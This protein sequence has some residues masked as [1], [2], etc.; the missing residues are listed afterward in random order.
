MAKGSWPLQRCNMTYR[1]LGRECCYLTSVEALWADVFQ[2]LRGEEK[3]SITKG[4]F[5]G[6][7]SPICSRIRTRK[8][9]YHT[10]HTNIFEVARAY[11]LLSG[12]KYAGATRRLPKLRDQSHGSIQRPY[13]PFACVKEHGSC[14]LSSSSKVSMKGSSSPNYSPICGRVPLMGKC[15]LTQPKWSMK[16]WVPFNTGVSRPLRQ[17]KMIQGWPWSNLSHS[18]YSRHGSCTYNRS[19]VCLRH[20]F[21]HVDRYQSIF[22]C[23]KLVNTWPWYT[24]SQR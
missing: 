12:R 16:L 4:D 10:T 5:G 2:R 15:F 9:H 20:L 11:S 8:R 17:Q 7:R 18:T 24:T 23:A 19:I 22:Q 21:S 14:A 1:G 3:I 6:I 13:S